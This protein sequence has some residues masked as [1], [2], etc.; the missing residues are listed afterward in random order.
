MKLDKVIRFF[1]VMYMTG[2]VF[3]VSFFI[4]FTEVGEMDLLE[5]I[6]YLCTLSLIGVGAIMTIILL[7]IQRFGERK[8]K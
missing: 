7:L 2:F 4:L 3:L 6:C 8:K 1:E 5:S